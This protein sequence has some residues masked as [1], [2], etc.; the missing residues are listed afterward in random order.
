MRDWFPSP[1][2]HL[3]LRSFEQQGRSS[4]PLPIF[5]EPSPPLPLVL[6]LTDLLLS[7]P[8]PLHAHPLTD[9]VTVSSGGLLSPFA[10]R[11]EPSLPSSNSS[12]ARS[13]LPVL[14][15]CTFFLLHLIWFTHIGIV[16][17]SYF[18]SF[19]GWMWILFCFFPSFCFWNLPFDLSEAKK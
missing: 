19:F 7:P 2:L 6:L 3:P 1:W 17:F 15:H 10:L 9:G 5:L 12:I 4:L 14:H 13:P 16:H 11:S 8:S 18:F